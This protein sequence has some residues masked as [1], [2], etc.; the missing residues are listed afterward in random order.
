[1]P[2]P[3][4]HLNATRPLSDKE[5]INI[6]ERVANEN[7]RKWG[8]PSATAAFDRI[9][10][11]NDYDYRGFYNANPRSRANADTHWPDIYKTVYHPTFSKDS[12][13]SNKVSKFNPNGLRGGT[14]YGDTFVPALWQSKNTINRYMDILGIPTK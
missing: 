3:K 10:N 13:Y 9:L 14:W 4:R 1:M 6:M 8:D 11:S 12:K 2:K 5:Y 7:W